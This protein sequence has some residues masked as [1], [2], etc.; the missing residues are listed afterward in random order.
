MSGGGLVRK[1]IGDVVTHPQTG[2][3]GEV[4]EVVT[5]PACLLRTLVIAWQSGGVEEMDELEFGPLED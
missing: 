2:E 1:Q 5:N 4:R 3:Q